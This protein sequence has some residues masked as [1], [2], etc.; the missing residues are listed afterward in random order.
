MMLLTDLVGYI[1][2][3]FIMISFIPQVF[4][5]YKTRSVK[6]LSTSMII[7]TFVGTAFWVA[8]GFF[9]NSMPVIIM[10]IIFGVIVIFQLYL[11]IKYD[12]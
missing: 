9:I 6:D 3:F 10:N 2:G 1:G 8:Y 4:K 5:S 7:A 11:K 12:K